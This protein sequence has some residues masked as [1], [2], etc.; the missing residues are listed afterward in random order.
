MSDRSENV[1]SSASEAGFTLIE[2]LVAILVLVFGL[3]AV[4]NLMLLAAS[5]NAAGNATTVATAIAS[6]RLETLK[7]I[8][9]QN[10]AI[11]GGIDDDM[12]ND[13]PAFVSLDDIPDV[14]K[15]YTQWQ[16][17]AIAGDNETRYI[18]VRSE[19]LG[20]LAGA[21]SRAEFTT[22]RTCTDQAAGCPAP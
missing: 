21:R 17:L 4:T 3:M 5:S 15:A 20:V 12:T 6:Q 8:P 7:A 18:R 16:V 22:F 10:L 2:A 11:G 13:D 14:G 9:F 19:V 1:T